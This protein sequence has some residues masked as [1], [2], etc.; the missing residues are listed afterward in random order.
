MRRCGQDHH[1]QAGN[2]LLAGA[3][4]NG[5]AVI[6]ATDRDGTQP[7]TRPWRPEDFGASIYHAL[8]ID[9]SNTYYPRL[10]RPTRISD[11]EVI[12]GLFA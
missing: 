2:A 11:G 8:G 5:G 7:A 9:Y 10:P 3:G 4:V 1:C 12:E 6:G